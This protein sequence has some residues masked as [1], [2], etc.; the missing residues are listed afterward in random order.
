M[1][2]VGGVCGEVEITVSFCIFFPEDTFV[3]TLQWYQ[4]KEE[5]MALD[6]QGKR[7]RKF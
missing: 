1:N 5:V 3:S 4:G 7:E 2:V 6:G